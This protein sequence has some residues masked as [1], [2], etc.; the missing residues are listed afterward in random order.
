MRKAE[1]NCSSQT[2]AILCAA[3][4][5]ATAPKAHTHSEIRRNTFC[6]ETT[7]LN[8]AGLGCQ[9]SPA[10]PGGNYAARRRRDFKVK[11]GEETAP[12]R[13]PER[14]FSTRLVGLH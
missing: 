2:R 13:R 14:R 6:T 3:D 7:Q 8:I 1:R 12:S 5:L 10:E 4:A 11:E 9:E